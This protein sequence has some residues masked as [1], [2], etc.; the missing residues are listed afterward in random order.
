MPKNE[1]PQQSETLRC[2]E[3]IGL[4]FF[5]IAKAGQR[6]VLAQPRAVGVKIKRRIAAEIVVVMPFSVNLPFKYQKSLFGIEYGE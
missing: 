1:A 3:D 2:I 6:L 5:P 4:N